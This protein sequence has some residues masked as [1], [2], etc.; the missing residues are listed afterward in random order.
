MKKNERVNLA[1][2][3]M[4]CSSCAN[5]IERQLKKVA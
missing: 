4:H 3:G 2:S 1:I 5:I